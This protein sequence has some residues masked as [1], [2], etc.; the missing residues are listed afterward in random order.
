MKDL[1]AF[2]VLCDFTS[3]NGKLMRTAGCQQ[4]VN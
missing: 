1:V 4:D 2:A 3:G